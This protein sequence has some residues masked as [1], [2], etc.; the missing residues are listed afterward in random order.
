MTSRPSTSI[1]RPERLRSAMCIAARCSVTIDGLAGE[2]R[3]DPFLEPAGARKLEQQL[4][5]ARGSAAAG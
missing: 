5:R 1:G 4:E 3:R 2:E